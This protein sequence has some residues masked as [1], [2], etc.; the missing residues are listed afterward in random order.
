MAFG[1][2]PESLN[3]QDRAR[4]LEAATDIAESVLAGGSTA[5]LSGVAGKFTWREETGAMVGATSPR[6]GEFGGQAVHVTVEWREGN[7][8]RS[9]RLDT[10]RLG[11]LP[12]G[13]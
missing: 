2:M 8:Q 6:P 7:N 12:R 13:T 9:I 1:G 4:N 10:L 11:I 3:A 5:A